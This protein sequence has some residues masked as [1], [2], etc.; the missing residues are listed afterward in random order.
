MS[1]EEIAGGRG[2]GRRVKSLDPKIF[3]AAT[4]RVQELTVDD[5][6]K[7]ASVASGAAAPS[8]NLAA[9]D[10][11]DIRS[12]DDTFHEA[13]LQ[14]ADLLARRLKQGAGVAEDEE[15]LDGW[16][17]CCCTPCCCCAAAD[18]DPFE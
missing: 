1:E 15:F 18:V 8:G 13:R 6:N 16:S 7:L 5:L 4:P 14:A 10:A 9:L 11:D 17:C 3:G 12:L 2:H